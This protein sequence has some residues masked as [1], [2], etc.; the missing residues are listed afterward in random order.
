MKIDM[1]GYVHS[2][3]GLSL[4]LIPETDVERVLLVNFWKHAKITK[5]ESLVRGHPSTF[6]IEWKLNH[7][8]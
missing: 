8:N 3:N 1:H 5:G 7:D 6:L 4:E 2:G